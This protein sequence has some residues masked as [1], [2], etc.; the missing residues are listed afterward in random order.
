LRK[1][2][3]KKEKKAKKGGGGFLSNLRDFE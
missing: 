1:E 2:N 3:A